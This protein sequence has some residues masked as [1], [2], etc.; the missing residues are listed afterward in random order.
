MEGDA[1][2][3]KFNNISVF[4][5]N[6]HFESF[7]SKELNSLF[8]F[9]CYSKKVRD[10][11][12]KSFLFQNIT[13]SNDSDKKYIFLYE[14]KK[15]PFYVFSDYDLQA[16]DKKLLESPKRI[17]NS[18]SRTLKLAGSMNLVNPRVSIGNSITGIFRPL[19]ILQKGKNEQVIDYAKN[20]VMDK[21][22][23]Y[24][25]FKFQEI[26]VV[27]KFDLYNIYYFINEFNDYKHIYE[28]LMFTKEILKELSWKE[29][30]KF[31]TKPY[32]SS[33]INKHNY[34]FLGNDHDCLFFQ[35]EDIYHQKYADLIQE[36]DNFTKNPTHASRHIS[37][38]KKKNVYQLKNR[39]F[40][41]F[42]FD[43][44]SDMVNDVE[45]KKQLLSDSRYRKCHKNSIMIARG[46]QEDNKKSAYVV[47]GKCK[48]NELDYYYHSWVEIDDKNL[49]IDYNHNIIMNRDQ[50]YRFFE[51]VAISKTKVE[52]LEEI[53]EVLIME[54]QLYFDPMDINYFGT[55][56]LRDI[57]KNMKVLKRK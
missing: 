24:E 21:N 31:L 56:L 19:I 44:L 27:D 10:L 25:L 13:K 4:I 49:V 54:A 39:K 20:L 2:M 52:E 3:E 43:L 14:G 12:S 6:E 51:T 29:E 28:Y 57:K 50:Y 30:F 33:G 45:I 55:E 11:Y 23:Y 40:G 8:Q 32:D 38:N 36:L 15:Y 17:K 16:F 1:A 37:Y 5:Q 34:V 22:D 9:T 26:N 41:Y 48:E 35:E 46:L 42:T 47:G 53:I 7:D 18:F